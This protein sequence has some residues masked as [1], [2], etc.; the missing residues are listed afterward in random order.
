[1]GGGR[2]EGGREI[3]NMVKE[4]GEMGMVSERG[5]GGGERERRGRGRVG[6]R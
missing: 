5:D 3:C 1:M 4:R 2:K 6:E